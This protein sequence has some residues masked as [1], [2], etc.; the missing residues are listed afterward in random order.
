MDACRSST[1]ATEPRVGLR[2][3]SLRSR[4]K[5]RL[6][7][8]NRF[9]SCT[10]RRSSAVHRL[11]TAQNSA[12]SAFVRPYSAWYEIVA[13]G[14]RRRAGMPS[15]ATPPIGVN[16]RYARYS[17]RRSLNSVTVGTVRRPNSTGCRSVAPT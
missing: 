2:G 16:R 4:A 1:R 17:E 3:L 8:A 9:N 5:A 10:R 15:E 6:P 7:T 13:D 14:R 11:N 12:G